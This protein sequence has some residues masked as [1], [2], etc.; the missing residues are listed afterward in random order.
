MIA[1]A[2]AGG[3][4]AGGA[5][6][7][8]ATG[9]LAGLLGL[10]LMSA[11]SGVPTAVGGAV[12]LLTGVAATGLKVGWRVGVAFASC[13]F[14][15]AMNCP[16]EGCGGCC[17]ISC[18]SAG[19]GGQGGVSGAFGTGASLELEDVPMDPGSRLAPVTSR[20]QKRH[21]QTSTCTL[22]V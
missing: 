13:C 7:G 11:V 4:L 16:A 20:M 3:D 22:H 10:L 6:G 19:V 9:A 17:F 1:G 21:L 15:W 8:L 2:L 18:C 12:G 14:Q 5:L